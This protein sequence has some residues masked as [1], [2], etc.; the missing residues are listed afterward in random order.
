MLFCMDLERIKKSRNDNPEGILKL[1]A[2]PLLT[3]EKRSGPERLATPSEGR[4]QDA[5]HERTFG[6]CSIPDANAGLI[7]TAVNPTGRLDI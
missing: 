2:S 7:R 3:G 1:V 4:A 6:R 5:N